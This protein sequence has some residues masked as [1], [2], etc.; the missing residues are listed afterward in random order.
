MTRAAYLRAARANGRA[1]GLAVAITVLAGWAL[2]LYAS[3]FSRAVADG[4]L[5]L[6][7]M[8][9][10]STTWFHTALF[11]TGHEAMH[12]LVSPGYPRINH[13][14]GWF[15]TRAFAH[16]DYKT[17]LHAHW[18]HHRCPAQAG[19]DPDFHNGT[20]RGV[21]P[22]FAT[23][24]LGYMRVSQLAWMG[25]SCALLAALTSPVRVLVGWVLPLL[26]SSVQLFF[27]GTYLPHR[28]PDLASGKPYADRHRARSEYGW[29]S[30]FHL[31]SC[32]NFGLH[33][34]HHTM[35]Y[36][37]WWRLHTVRFDKVGAPPEVASQ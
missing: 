14:I 26:A 33:H 23:F 27:F 15:C 28:D 7:L 12:G 34:E 24:M 5:A 32:L 8:A 35:P 30:Q 9:V 21:I 36:I 10:A 37:P 11:I 20:H 29:S 1:G 16:L 25:A 13:A 6:R 4:P 31:L 17:L 19:K 2:S 22:W 3:L 18:A